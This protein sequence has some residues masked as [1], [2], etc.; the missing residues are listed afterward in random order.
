VD[1]I[2]VGRAGVQLRN[3][4]HLPPLN[5]KTISAGRAVRRMPCY[6]A[7]RVL[8]LRLPSLLLCKTARAGT[9]PGRRTTPPLPF[10]AVT[11]GQR[12]ALAAGALRWAW[13]GALQPRD[14]ASWRSPATGILSPGERRAGGGGVR[15]AGRGRGG[16]D[17]L[18]GGYLE[19]FSGAA[20]RVR[21][22]WRLSRLIAACC[23]SGFLCWHTFRRFRFSVWRAEE[24]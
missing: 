16:G 14:C 10:S 17:G 11:G 3:G 13:T 12:A 22:L 8:L 23:F 21:R 7:G 9:S 6:S 4:W 20:W 15:R 5:L 24:R 2:T 18:K 1:G 19:N